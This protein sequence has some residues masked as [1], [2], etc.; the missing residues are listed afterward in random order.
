[1]AQHKALLIG[2]SEYGDPSIGHLPFVRD[3]LQRLREVLIGRGFQQAEIVES[4]YG[5][6]QNTVRGAVHRF[7]H[8]AGRGDTLLILLSG[9]GV[10]FDGKDYLVPEDATSDTRPFTDSCIEIGWHKDVE[11]SPAERV[12]FLIDACREGMELDTMAI[13]GTRPWRAPAIISTLRRKIAYVHACA[14]PQVALF[15]RESDVLRPGFAVGTQEGESFSIFSR[16][17]SDVIADDPH[18]LGLREFAQQVQERVDTFH[19]A[20]GKAQAPQRVKVTCETDAGGGDFLLLPGSDRRTEVHP[21]VRGVDK[22]PVW[23]HTPE[24]PARE[25]LQQICAALAGRL[26]V[27]YDSA[28][29]ALG[30]DP[31]HDPQLATRTHERLGFLVGKADGVRLSPTEAALAFLFPLVTQTFWAQE[32]VQRVGVLTPDA[33]NPG[34]DQARFHKF[35][36]GFPRLKRRLLAL[37]HKRTAG[38]SKTTAGSKTADDS[39]K[40]ILW[41]LFRRWLIQQPDLYTAERLKALLGDVTSDGEHPW[42]SDAL[43]GER[44]MRLLRDHRTTPF[45]TRRA[46]TDPVLHGPGPHQEDREIIAASGLYEQEV[47]TPLVTALVKAAYGMAVDPMDLPEIVVEHLGVRDSVDLDALRTT[48]QRSDWRVSGLGRSLN[49]VCTHPAVQVALREHAARVDLLLRDINRGDNPVLAP[50]STLPPYADGSRVRLDGNTPDQLSDGIRFQLAEDR[51]QE[52]LMGEELYGDSELAVRELYQNALDAVR[53]RDRRTE[54]LER[55]NRPVSWEGGSIEFVQ[56]V[57]PDGRPYLK[58]TDNGI[59][60]GITELST[61]FSQGGARFVDLPEYIE[62]QAAWAELP[63]PKLELHPNS[64]FGIGVLSYFMLADEIVVR[65]CR[66]D[67]AGRPGRLLQVTI[68]G[69]GNF[70]RVDDLGPGQDAGTEVELLLSQERRSVS[71]VDALQKVLWVAP[72]RTVARHGARSDEW[73]PGQLSPATLE[74]SDSYRFYTHRLRTLCIPSGDLDVWWIEG[75]GVTLADGLFAESRQISHKGPLYG[76]VVNLHGER[77]PELTVDRK[78][79]RSYDRDHVTARMTATAASLT[80]PGLELPT[81][82][83]LEGTSRWSVAFAD[84]VAEHARRAGLPWRLRDDVS[85]PFG[86]VGFFRP[87]VDL[88]PLVT[89][90]YTGTDQV[91]GASF[92]T[93]MPLPVLRWRLRTLY[94]AGLGGPTSLPGTDATDSLCARPSDL[95]LL[96]NDSAGFPAWK[97]LLRR[98]MRG[99]Q[100]SGLLGMS[101]SSDIVI[102][103]GLLSLGM[104]F[105]WRDPAQPVGTA[106]LFELSS[107]VERPPTE[108][109]ERLNCLGYCTESLSGCAAVECSDL[110]LLRP[111][112]DLSK[113]LAPGSALSAAQICVSAAQAGC[114]TAQAAER[115]AQL[116]FTVPAEYPMRT[117]WSEEELNVINQLWESYD[118]PPSPE[119]AVRVCAAQLSAVALATS[120]T[121]HFVAEFLA[122]LGFRMPPD[123]SDLPELTDD[124]R[125]LLTHDPQVQ[126]DQE[127]PLRYVAAASRRLNRPARTLAEQLRELGYRVSEVPD[128][129][130]LPSREDIAFLELA[131]GLNL[132]RPVSL[133]QLV[134]IAQD[135]DISPTEAVARLTSLGFRFAFDSDVVSRFRNQ[136]T[137]ALYFGNCPEPEDSGV[138]SP[139]DLHAIA[140]HTR[141]PVGTDKIAA[142]LAGLG[143]TV[144]PRPEEWI[145]ERHLEE[146]LLVALRSQ[147]DVH[148]PHL[149]DNPQISLVALAYVALETRMPLRDA[150]VKAS[151]M[152]I[153]HEAETWF[154]PAPPPEPT[155][156]SAAATPPPSAAAPPPGY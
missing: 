151:A 117:H 108:V 88:V 136:D 1:M 83:W 53:Y 51:V 8:G 45:T 152:G 33:S 87:D 60:M 69:P 121:L 128:D 72:Y 112:G 146:L 90:T 98:W 43:S 131:P 38:G 148:I 102:N 74:R 99:P 130:H 86:Q 132:H 111:L 52:L 110:P 59:G 28:T 42:V 115:L 118:T 129:E 126:V 27:A 84:C 114:S 62:E 46:T 140:L 138:V 4:R 125:A 13:P 40:H 139:A 109:A 123:V 47:R 35:A 80:Q 127:V 78:S 76:V 95:M 77:A 122:E 49:A 58:C 44:M 14:K 68:A 26:A 91:S 25:T 119:A 73:K 64:R 29:A 55:M 154:T 17:V 142:S 156:P 137:E 101:P 81:A 66:L 16:A 18:A 31:W 24:G 22:H 9:H 133:K 116:G 94:R 41:W 56:G 89:G 150:A 113:W 141:Q 50:L 155:A 11:R 57:H 3:D 61:V 65:T 107:K 37:E 92:L 100:A 54:Y 21:W 39:T 7:L 153:R 134:I 79:V 10:H 135:A 30:D 20:Y 147:D 82:D 143:F 124:D 19:R 70:F 6:T 96:I 97:H 75:E 93:T 67:R 106:D 105:P 2:A 63:G 149:P 71:C 36:Q 145:D 5:I 144:A 120:L 85:A 32:G 15:V 23:H 104:L 34:P 12:V 48:V 103:S